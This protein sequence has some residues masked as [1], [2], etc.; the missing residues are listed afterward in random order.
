MAKERAQLQ[1]LVATAEPSTDNRSTMALC[2]FVYSP[3]GY[4]L[5]LSGE[6]DLTNLELRVETD[7]FLVT[8]KKCFW[9]N[10]YFYEVSQLI[11]ESRG[12]IK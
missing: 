9:Y 2:S 4:F 1:G 6:K 3:C 11:K 12:Q 7:C 5:F 10:C 8:L